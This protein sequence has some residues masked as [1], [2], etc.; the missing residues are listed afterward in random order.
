MV[1]TVRV[2]LRVR[3]AESQVT[4]LVDREVRINGKAFA[5]D[6]VLGPQTSQQAVFSATIERDISAVLQGYA[7]TVFAYGQTGSGKTHSLLGP[8]L[9]TENSGDLGILP[10]SLEWIFSQIEEA[11]EH[12]EFEIKVAMCEVFCERVNDLLDVSKKDLK[13]REKSGRVVAEGL[14]HHYIASRRDAIRLCVKGNRNR[15]TGETAMNLRSSRSHAIFSICCTVRDEETLSHGVL[16]IVDLA[17]SE[18]LKRSDL[19]SADQVTESKHINTSLSALGNV[20]NVLASDKH[21]H[22]PYRDSKLTRILQNS[23]NGKS[24]M[25]LFCTISPAAE[26]T[27]ESLGTLRFGMRAKR[28]RTQPVANVEVTRAELLTRID[29]LEAVLARKTVQIAQL[30][31][32][33]SLKSEPSSPGCLRSPLE[34]AELVINKLEWT[35]ERLSQELL[36]KERELS[37]EKARLVVSSEGYAQQLELQAEGVKEKDAVIASLQL[38]IE[39]LRTPPVILEPMSTASPVADDQEAASA[40]ISSLKFS[41]DVE[42]PATDNIE[43][44]MFQTPREYNRPAPEMPQTLLIQKDTRIRCLETSL[45]TLHKRFQ[46]TL[47]ENLELKIQQTGAQPTI[48]KSFLSRLVKPMKGGVRRSS[49][50]FPSVFASQVVRI[51]AVDE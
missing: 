29:D 31:E 44:V 51:H 26:D 43:M 33:L 50:T 22:V 32:A 11:E 40:S 16:H 13:L 21:G 46:E 25:W 2:A 30:A 8:A 38:E 1:D 9:D 39:A 15:K 6:V 48:R 10:R 19:H 41:S 4:E 28:I 14:S 24:K 49:P 27:S 3:P 17:G 5:F 7:L 23:L 37:V 35:V 18:N 34:D 42:S 36:E 47:R 12:L 20:I 45:H